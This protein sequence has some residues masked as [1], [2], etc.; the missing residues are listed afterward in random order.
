MQHIPSLDAQHGRVTLTLPDGFTADTTR[1]TARPTL[2]DDLYVV[3]SGDFNA[4][5]W[6]VEAIQSSQGLLVDP[7]TIRVEEFKLTIDA[8]STLTFIQSATNR[9]RNSNRPIQIVFDFTIVKEGDSAHTQA[10]FN[11]TNGAISASGEP[12]VIATVDGGFG[13]TQE[14]LLTDTFNAARNAARNTQTA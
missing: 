10:H 11:H 8:T 6:R 7:H 1:Y 4:I 5:A 12:P 9:T 3:Q 2:P 13:E 14:E